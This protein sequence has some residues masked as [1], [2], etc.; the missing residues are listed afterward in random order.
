MQI[1]ADE[2]RFLPRG[3]GP[4]RVPLQHVRRVDRDGRW[5]RVSLRD[6]TDWCLW[7][8]R[9]AAEDLFDALVEALEA[10]GQTVPITERGG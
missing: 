7:C 2:L 4:D 1:D 3:A 9:F 8:G 6:R 10:R 5:V